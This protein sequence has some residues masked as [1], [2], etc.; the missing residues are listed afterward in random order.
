M[1]LIIPDAGP[2]HRITGHSAGRVFSAP[3]VCGIKPLDGFQGRIVIQLALVLLLL[4]VPAG[5]DSAGPLFG[6]GIDAPDVVFKF[7]PD[8]TEAARAVGKEGI[9]I[10][11][12]H[13]TRSGTV[14]STEVLRGL[15]YGLDE[16]ARDTVAAW[17]FRPGLLDGKPVDVW[18]TIAVRFQANGPRMD[19]AVAL[20]EL[21][22]RAE[23]GEPWARFHLGDML[24]NGEL[25]ERDPLQ[26]HAWLTL[27]AEQ[28]IEDA[29]AERDALAAELTAD[30]LAEAER[31]LRRLKETE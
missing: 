14:G 22:A 4:A 12:T 6:C 1:V 2:G 5:R 18:F 8:S 11:K 30:E 9:V 20:V 26:A 21:R 3:L 27:A 7:D 10:L 24:R 31:L 15:G 16:Q 25:V 13:I 28:G 19:R 23:A 29:A 17:R